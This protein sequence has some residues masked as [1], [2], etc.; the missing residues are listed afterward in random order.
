MYYKVVSALKKKKCSPNQNNIPLEKA[1]AENFLSSGKVC[2]KI[3][4]II[5]KRETSSPVKS[6]EKWFSG[7]IFSNVKVNW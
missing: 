2:K 4:Q 3:Y 1:A 6:Q 7:D 5:F